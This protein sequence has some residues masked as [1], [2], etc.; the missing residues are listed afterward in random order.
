MAFITKYNSYLIVKQLETNLPIAITHDYF[1]RPI[2]IL[3]DEEIKRL[4]VYRILL[5]FPDKFVNDYYKAIPNNYSYIFYTS[6]AF[7]SISNCE[8]LL[9]NFHNIYLPKSIKQR[10]KQE[11]IKFKDWC[12]EHKYLFE[13]NQVQTFIDL[14]AFH[15]KIHKSEFD[16]VNKKNSGIDY[17]ENYSLEQLDELIEAL[18]AKAK[19]YYYQSTKNKIIIN[20]FRNKIFLR[21]ESCQI[22]YNN[23][24]FDDK[25]V[26]E[27]LT[28]LYDEFI[29]KLVYYLQEW[30]RVSINPE[31]SFEGLL[32]EQ[33]GFSQCKNCSSSNNFIIENNVKTKI[34][35]GEDLFEI[36]NGSVNFI[37]YA[38]LIIL[39]RQ[40][41][42]ET[43]R[44]ENYSNNDLE[45]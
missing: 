27:V 28:H 43:D 15:F 5:K 31:L 21:R 29:N 34:D 19:E 14:A 36:V 25:E 45:F 20:Q 13:N 17:K 39:S 26:K 40:D 16:V 6:S 30:L 7:H 42:N 22:K 10:G 35:N 37:G 1:K 18:L 2:G 44:Q 38:E 4:L 12:E 11:I 9:A 41:S 24:G 32:L 33:L 23:T 3:S 8:R